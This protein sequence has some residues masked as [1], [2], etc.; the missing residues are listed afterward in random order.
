MLFLQEWTTGEICACMDTV[1]TCNCSNPIAMSPTVGP[2]MA[3]ASA[4]KASPI[5]AT[6]AQRASALG[7]GCQGWAVAAAGLN[8]NVSG[9]GGKYGHRRVHSVTAVVCYHNSACDLVTVIPGWRKRQAWVKMA[10]LWFEQL[11][12]LYIKNGVEA[13]LEHCMLACPSCFCRSAAIVA[14]R[15]RRSTALRLVA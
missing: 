7:Q 14:W 2:A 9:F 11:G 4:A 5:V 3:E 13:A 1:L 15:G 10:G 8:S 12:A 6:T